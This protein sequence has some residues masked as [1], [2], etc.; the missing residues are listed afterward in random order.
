M[1]II[2]E[3]KIPY[4]NILRKKNIVKVVKNA[5]EKIQKMK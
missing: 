3:I 1:K 4:L 2:K 5:M